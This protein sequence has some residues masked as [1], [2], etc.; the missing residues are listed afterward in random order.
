MNDDDE[1]LGKGIRGNGGISDGENDAYKMFDKMLSN[2]F[3]TVKEYYDAFIPFSRKVGWSGMC[4]VSMFISRLQPPIR[5]RVSSHNPKTLYDAY[6]WAST[7]ETNIK[8][9][10]ES[11]GK[12]AGYNSVVVD[13]SDCLKNKGIKIVTTT[14]KNDV[15]KEIGNGIS[16]ANKVDKMEQKREIGNGVIDIS[17]GLMGIRLMDCVVSGNGKMEQQREIGNDIEGEEVIESNEVNG[18]IDITT[19]LMDCEDK[20]GVEDNCEENVEGVGMELDDN[21]CLGDID[22]ICTKAGKGNDLGSNESS[23]VKVNGVVIV[24]EPMKSEDE[25]KSVMSVA[26]FFGYDGT[27]E[28]LE[29]LDENGEEED[30]N[31][32][33]MESHG[34]ITNSFGL[35]VLG[36]ICKEDVEVKGIQSKNLKE[37]DGNKNCLQNYNDTVKGGKL[38]DNGQVMCG[39]RGMSKVAWKPLV[40]MRKNGSIIRENSG[41]A[42]CVVMS[43]DDFVLSENVSGVKH[44]LKDKDMESSGVISNNF[45]GIWEDS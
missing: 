23:Q 17:I 21:S 27:R 18:V 29:S 35:Q 4:V 40:K 13:V 30:C 10:M 44:V 38:M 37:D 15:N 5:T 26:E 24:D 8:H 20:Y 11:C 31:I 33:E 36:E 32:E 43:I 12:N 3:G 42:D 19:G 34:V 41:D 7:Q 39:N 22:E 45:K 1:S 28:D 6:C 2:N 9:L 14:E 25:N 16:V